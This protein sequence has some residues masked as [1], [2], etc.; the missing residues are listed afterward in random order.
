MYPLCNKTNTWCT[1]ACVRSIFGIDTFWP[2]RVWQQFRRSAL[3]RH[4]LFLALH[5][6]QWQRPLQPWVKGAALDDSFFLFGSSFPF[7]CPLPP[8]LFKCSSFRV[9]FPFNFFIGLQ[10][11]I[12]SRRTKN[13]TSQLNAS[14]SGV[15]HVFIILMINPPWMA[16]VTNYFPNDHT[17]V[18]QWC[19]FPMQISPPD[20]IQGFK[21]WESDPGWRSLGKENRFK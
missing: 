2:E 12:Q 4:P 16:T 6:L 18:I 1:S 21:T 19:G 7:I 15:W 14:T 20:I 5:H 3:L 8:F 11:V 9:P 17:G 13:Q 10:E